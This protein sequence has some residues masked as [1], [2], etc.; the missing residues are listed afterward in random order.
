L[1]L[2]AFFRASCLGASFRRLLLRRRLALALL[3]TAIAAPMI[4]VACG[5]SGSSSPAD[6]TT[7]VVPLAGQP[8]TTPL[9]TTIATEAAPSAP[10]SP[11][12]ASATGADCGPKD[13]KIGAIPRD[14]VHQYAAA[15]PMIVDPAKQ[16]T[17]LIKTSKGD[18]TVA[19]D[20]AN[21]PV[22][23]N[24]FVFL[25][26]HGFYDGLT[27]HRV[28]KTPQPF[29]IQGGDPKGDGTGGPGYQF[30]NEIS[31]NL[32]HVV[33]A[34]AMANS[35]PNTNGSQFYITLSAQPGL[36]GTY[37]V[38]GKVSNGMDVANQIAVGDK[39]VSIAIQEK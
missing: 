23:T 8:V 19:L 34:I 10:A 38:F 32:K 29:V 35:G 5:S 16:Y 1:S 39:I 37:N 11:A 22:T 4:A 3:C 26:C 27:F 20:A 15:P 25:S 13:S 2:I 31:P 28:V 30:K 33:G 17:A 12:P 7:V 14:M 36:D 18:I 6:K 24:N 9:P 21:A